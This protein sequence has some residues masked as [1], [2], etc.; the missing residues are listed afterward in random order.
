MN[1]VKFVVK[2]DKKNQQYK[3]KVNLIRRPMFDDMV[4]VMLRHHCTQRLPGSPSPGLLTGKHGPALT[5]WALTPLGDGFY[6]AF[7]CVLEVAK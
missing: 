5:K 3:E 2:N 4:H 6:I 1:L 7:R